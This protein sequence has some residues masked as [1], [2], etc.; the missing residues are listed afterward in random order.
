[1]DKRGKTKRIKGFTLVEL[2]VVIAIIAVLAAILVPT[3]MGWVAQSKIKAA[4]TNAKETFKAASIVSATLFANG[5]K[6][7]DVPMTSAGTGLAG[8]YIQ[9]TP[10]QQ[11]AN[12]NIKMGV[13]VEEHVGASC[14]IWDYISYMCNEFPQL[15]NSTFSVIFDTSDGKDFAPP[16]A[17][18]WSKNSNDKYIGGSPKGATKAGDFAAVNEINCAL[19]L[20]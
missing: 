18:L 8:F 9:T 7:P 2:I 19:A 3:M 10:G 1:M 16:L 17:A 13:S 6:S 5:V 14:G 20:K 4:N 15:R 12:S 11:N